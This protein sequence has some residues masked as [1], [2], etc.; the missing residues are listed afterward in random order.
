MIQVTPSV[1]LPREEITFTFARSRGPGG[2]NVNKVSTQATLHFNVA[3]STALT[4]E[5][6]SRIHQKLGRRITQAGVL[7]VTSRKY[8]TQAANR[9][10]ALQRFVELLAE[11]LRPQRKRKPTRPTAASREKRLADKAHRARIK[12]LRR[13]RPEQEG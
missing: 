2:Q 1:W 11:A 7:H 3:E 6:K 9:R 4:A 12:R 8:R 13:R 10:A 5:Q